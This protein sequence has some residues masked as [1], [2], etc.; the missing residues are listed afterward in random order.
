M[1]NFCNA[2]G[3][4]Y[5]ENHGKPVQL[6]RYVLM[7]VNGGDLIMSNTAGT[8]GPKGSALCLYLVFCYGP[9][10]F[11]HIS[12]D[13]LTVIRAYLR[14]SYYRWCMP[15]WIWVNWTWKETNNGCFLLQRCKSSKCI[16]KFYLTLTLGCNT[17]GFS[18][19]RCL[20]NTDRDGIGCTTRWMGPIW[21]YATCQ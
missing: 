19:M 12:L 6:N 21:G 8:I 14:F 3:M 5:L 1:P 2:M 17:T 10:T 15:W 11:I 18:A 7:S 13:Y 9:I 16:Y 4:Y 20:S